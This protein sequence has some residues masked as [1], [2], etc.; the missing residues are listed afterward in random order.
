[1]PD[2]DN[3]HEGLTIQA[4]EEDVFQIF[5]HVELDNIGTVIH[6]DTIQDSAEEEAIGIRATEVVDKEQITQLV[7]VATGMITV[8][9]DV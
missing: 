1:M 4:I 5:Q 7:V 2:Q 8:K 3:V 9:L 6:A